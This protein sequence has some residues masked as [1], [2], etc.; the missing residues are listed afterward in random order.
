MTSFNGVFRFLKHSFDN[1][2]QQFV[3][4]K[5]DRFGIAPKII[6]R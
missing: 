2:E 3:I 4:T 6:K 5:D 1:C